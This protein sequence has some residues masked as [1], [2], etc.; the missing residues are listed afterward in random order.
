VEP[1]LPHPSAQDLKARLRR[2]REQQ[3]EH[4]AKLAEFAEQM[5]EAAEAFAAMLEAAA[6]R[7]DATRRLAVAAAE[8]EVARIQRRNAAKL[9]NTATGCLDLE[10]LPHLPQFEVS[11]D[12]AREP[13]PG[14]A[15]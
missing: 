2:L 3:L 6:S 14:E 5:A 12:W 15:E 11:L 10:H 8:R 7:G 1:T 9:R 13:P 4:H